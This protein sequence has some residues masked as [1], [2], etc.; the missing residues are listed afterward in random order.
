[1]VVLHET[2]GDAAGRVLLRVVRLEVRDLAAA[3]ARTRLEL[4]REI[5]KDFQVIYLTTSDRYHASADAVVALAGPT[6]VD[7]GETAVQRMKRQPSR[8]VTTTVTQLT[9]NE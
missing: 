4:L 7:D 5:A 2:A 1:M 6:E 3:R 8:E 9:I